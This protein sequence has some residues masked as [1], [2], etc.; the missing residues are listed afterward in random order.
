MLDRVVEVGVTSVETNLVTQPVVV[1]A[2]DMQLKLLLSMYPGM[3]A[4]QVPYS[5]QAVHVTGHRLQS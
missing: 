3:Q 1:M 2:P 5:E 4:E